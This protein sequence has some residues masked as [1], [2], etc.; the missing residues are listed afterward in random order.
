LSKQARR[1]DA[2]LRAGDA[3]DRSVG[4]PHRQRG[5][6]RAL[7]ARKSGRGQRVDVPMFE[8]P[9]ADGD[10]RHMGGYTFL[11]QQGAPGYAR[12]LAKER[13][14]YE[15]KDGP[16]LRAGLQRQAV[17]RVLR[18]DRAA[19]T[20]RRPRYATPEA[21]SRDFEGANALVAAELK[22]RSNRGLDRGAERADIRCSA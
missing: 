9:A 20:V 1:R 11:P 6:R 12:M 8:R 22:K 10:G 5:L 13:R 14:P 7:L 3:R 21:R 18:I 2:A 16:R 17:A 19:G 15:T 4:L